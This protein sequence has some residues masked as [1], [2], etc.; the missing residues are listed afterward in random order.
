[1]GKVIFWLVVIFVALFALRMYNVAKTRRARPK[2]RADT[3]AAM[4]RCVQCGVFLP[5]PDAVETTTGY[6]C[7]DPACASR[8]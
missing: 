5:K 7:Q 1:V 6:R 3:P 2:Q 4:V 8:H